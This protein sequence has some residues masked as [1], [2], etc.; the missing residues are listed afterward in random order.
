MGK[1]NSSTFSLSQ[2][3]KRKKLQAQCFSK[4]FYKVLNLEAAAV[5]LHDKFIQENP[6]IAKK[7]RA[8][9]NARF[10]ILREEDLEDDDE[11][12]EEEEEEEQGGKKKKKATDPTAIVWFRQVAIKQAWAQASE[13]HRRA[14]IAD[15]EK[16]NDSSDNNDKDDDEDAFPK[17]KNKKHA[18]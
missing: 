3:K 6:A 12:E 16:Q 18:E 10:T 7:W 2:R 5:A 15:W 8:T 9:P 11:E 14:T 4:L 13:E 1:S 17:T